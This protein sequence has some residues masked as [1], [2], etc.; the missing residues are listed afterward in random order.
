MNPPEFPGQDRPAAGESIRAAFRSARPAWNPSFLLPL[1][2]ISMVAWLV[3][4]LVLPAVDQQGLLSAGLRVVVVVRVGAAAWLT[5]A[6]VVALAAWEFGRGERLGVGEGVRILRARWTAVFA[7][8]LLAPLGALFF[9]FILAGGTVVL[10]VLPI[11][12]KILVPVWLLIVGLPLA[13]LVSGLLL[14]GVPGLPLIFTA[15]VVEQPFPFDAASRGMSY[16][17]AR[18]CRYL[19]ILTSG[20]LGAIAGTVVFTLFVLLV[21]SI[22]AARSGLQPGSEFQ[23]DELWRGLW[24]AVQSA[25]FTW[26]FSGLLEKATGLPFLGGESRM[27]LPVLAGRAV[28]AFALASVLTALARVYLLL[29]WDVDGELPASQVR[30]GEEFRWE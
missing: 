24:M 5:A 21:V 19:A 2:L 28:T 18:P 15:S 27:C 23:W 14:L 8:P 12:G 11:V 16:L 25:E 13:L 10:N 26:P 22:L 7:G 4:E 29:R 17:R 1:W 30:P 9:L 20:I 6:L 3:W